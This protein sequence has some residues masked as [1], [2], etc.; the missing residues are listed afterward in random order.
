LAKQ[1]SSKGI[2][3]AFFIKKKSVGISTLDLFESDFFCHLRIETYQVL[4]TINDSSTIL[5][6]YS[7]EVDLSIFQKEHI[8]F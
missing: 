5:G 4:I 1:A 8:E 7:R 2:E 6:D 3:F